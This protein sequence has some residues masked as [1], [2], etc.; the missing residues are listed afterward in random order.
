LTSGH[1][2]DVAVEA[3]AVQV[4]VWLE[5]VTGGVLV[6]ADQAR[7]AWEVFAGPGS[8]VALEVLDVVAGVH[9]AADFP[10]LPGAD[11]TLAVALVEN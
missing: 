10:Q 7:S 3:G 2:A 1:A 11:A 9:P 6:P 4:A 5:L 8:G